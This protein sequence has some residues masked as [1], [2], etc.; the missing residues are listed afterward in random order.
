[1]GANVIAIQETNG[2]G[3]TWKNMAKRIS[4]DDSFTFGTVVA[5]QLWDTIFFFVLAWYLEQVFPGEFGIPRPFYFPFMPSFWCGTSTPTEEQIPLLSMG[6]PSDA[7][8]QREPTGHAGIRIQGLCK[9]F[10]IKVAV[11]NT[12]LNL[13]EGQITALLGHNGAGKTTTMNLITGLYPPS[14]GTVLVDSMDIRKNLR[15]VQE[16]LGIC[17]QH[18]VY[19]SFGVKSERQS[20][21]GKEETEYRAEDRARK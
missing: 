3:V 13:F 20:R 16:T 12:S 6:S 11:K 17:P 15:N 1:M 8:F 14:S 2:E 4:I 10:G 19:I 21:E 7:R 5:M 18:G 9:K